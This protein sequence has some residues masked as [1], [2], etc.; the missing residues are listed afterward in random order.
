MKELRQQAAK[1]EP[2]QEMEI[3]FEPGLEEK[4]REALKAK[5]ERDRKE[6]MSV[7]DSYLEK[8]KEK[9]KQKSMW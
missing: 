4:A 3:S 2:D 9:R 8:R 5:A 6:D 7:W 1:E